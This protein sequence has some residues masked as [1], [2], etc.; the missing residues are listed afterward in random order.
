[1]SEQQCKIAAEIIV[2][3]AGDLPIK[4]N[5]PTDKYGGN[6]LEKEEVGLDVENAGVSPDKIWELLFVDIQKEVSLRI[7]EW[8]YNILMA[9]RK[10]SVPVELS[11]ENNHSSE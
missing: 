2:D 3:S 9:T 6:S 8:M 10:D 1:M 5:T 7:A 11:K 4:S